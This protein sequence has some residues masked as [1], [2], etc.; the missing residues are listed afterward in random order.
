ML[1]TRHVAAFKCRHML[2]ACTLTNPTDGTLSD[3]YLD[4]A[5][6]ANLQ[7]TK[8]IVIGNVLPSLL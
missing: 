1:D 6:H 5:S 2:T 3:V 7:C 8:A 4:H